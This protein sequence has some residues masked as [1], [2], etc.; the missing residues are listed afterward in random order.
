MHV[1]L[2]VLAG[3]AAASVVVLSLTFGIV[4]RGLRRANRLLPDRRTPAP[5]VWR[6]S[7]RRA[8]QLHR[9]LQRACALLQ[10]TAD[11]LAEARR[12]RR[13]HR[14]PAASPSVLGAAADELLQRALQTDACLAEVDR[15]GGPWRRVHLPA[16]ASEV[17]AV[18]ASALRLARLRADLDRSQQPVRAAPA[19]ELLDA[20]EAA[21][22]DLRSPPG[23]VP[24][25]L[26]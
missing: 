16:L 18:E 17:R 14:R 11:P 22:A 15:R 26:R 4:L 10:A 8:A 6:W 1:L 7:P 3:A 9:R 5:L 25:P 13:W 20:Y 24:P 21:L 12:A 2:E 19:E 23:P